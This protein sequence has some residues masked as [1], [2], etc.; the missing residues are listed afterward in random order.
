[1]HSTYA[2]DQNL[3][4]RLYHIYPILA[5]TGGNTG[6]YIRNTINENVN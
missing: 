1:M 5:S 2:K 3:N 4:H 6:M